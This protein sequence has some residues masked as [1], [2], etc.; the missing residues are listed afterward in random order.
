MLS[1][2]KREP[3]SNIRSKSLHSFYCSSFKLIVL[4]IGIFENEIRTTAHYY[5]ISCH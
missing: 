1:K 5:F 2:T 3:H 4:N